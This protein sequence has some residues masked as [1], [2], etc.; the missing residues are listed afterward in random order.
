MIVDIILP[1]RTF[2]K[3][4]YRLL[5]QM[6]LAGVEVPAGFVTDGASVP[7]LL[8]WLFPPTG[9]YFL[10]AVVHDYLLDSGYNWHYAN[11]KF[12]EA[13]YVQGVSPWVRWSM[14][15]AVQVY[16]FVKREILRYER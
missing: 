7:R 6:E 9:R 13:L 1:Q 16:Q 11:K 14:F 12:A 10:A 4:T 3:T 2:E 5:Q 15:S 8:W